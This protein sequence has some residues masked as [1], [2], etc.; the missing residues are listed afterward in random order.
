MLRS[1]TLRKFTKL[2]SYRYIPPDSGVTIATGIDLKYQT[3]K[4]MKDVKKVVASINF[5]DRIRPFEGVSGATAESSRGVNADELVLTL[6]EAKNLDK[7]Y[8]VSKMIR[9]YADVNVV[10]R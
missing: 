10:R 3:V 9:R 1:G 4:E 7:A 5:F 8:V 2:T 6:E